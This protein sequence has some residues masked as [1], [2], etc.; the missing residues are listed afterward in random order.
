[1]TA[2]EADLEEVKKLLSQTSKRNPEYPVQTIARFNGP[3][4]FTLAGTV[5]ML[6]V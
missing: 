2:V 6:K 4:S 5:S 3:R 1:M